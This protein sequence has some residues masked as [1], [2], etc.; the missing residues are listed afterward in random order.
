MLHILFLMIVCR[1]D[2]GFVNIDTGKKNVLYFKKHSAHSTKNKRIA[3]WTYACI[4]GFKEY[5]VLKGDGTDPI[6]QAVWYFFEYKKNVQWLL[7]GIRKRLDVGFADSNR[8]F[9]LTI[10]DAMS[11]NSL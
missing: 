10:L 1:A 8:H 6:G 11:R 3:S 7:Y 4:D 5:S 9:L 2:R